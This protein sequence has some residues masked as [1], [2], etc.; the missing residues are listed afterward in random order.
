MVE[1]THEA[2]GVSLVGAN[3]VVDFDQALLDDGCDFS[4]SQGILQSV[5][6]EYGEGQGFAKLMGTRRGTRGLQNVLAALFAC[7]VCV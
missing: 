2:S 7:R 3:F 4:A 1:Q 5:A 6:E